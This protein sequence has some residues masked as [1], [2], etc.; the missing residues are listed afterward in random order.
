MKPIRYMLLG[1]LAIIIFSGCSKSSKEFIEELK[2][3]HSNYKLHLFY[4]DGST[5]YNEMNEVQVFIN[6]SPVFK[7][8]ITEM[9]GHDYSERLNKKLKKLGI[10]TY[11]MYVLMNKDGVVYKSPYLSEMKSLIKQELKLN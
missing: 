4:T 6:S 5:P 10:T 3:Q 11:P 1:F 9:N 2:P 7:D 8:N